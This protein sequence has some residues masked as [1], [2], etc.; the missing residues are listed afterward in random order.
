LHEVHPKL[1][2][3]DRLHQDKAGCESTVL[4]CGRIGEEV[5]G[6]RMRLT[7]YLLWLQLY[8]L[9]CILIFVPF[10]LMRFRYVLYPDRS[11]LTFGYAHLNNTPA[12]YGGYRRGKTSRKG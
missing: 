9:L 3:G 8:F 11:N 4:T 12:I 7:F 1:S 10:N 6:S 2:L 5:C